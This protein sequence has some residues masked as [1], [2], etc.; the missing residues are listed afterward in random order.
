MN[1]ASSLESIDS[2]FLKIVEHPLQY[3]HKAVFKHPFY[4]KLLNETFNQGA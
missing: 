2:P 1:S 3:L 4:E